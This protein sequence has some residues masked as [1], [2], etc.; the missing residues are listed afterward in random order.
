M[1]GHL[2]RRR[3][4]VIPAFNEDESL[5]ILLTDLVPLLSPSDLV[6]VVDDSPAEIAALTQER[7]ESITKTIGISTIYLSS[8]SKSGRGNAVRRGLKLVLES[9]SNV[10]WFLECD[11]DGSH[12]P[13]DIMTVLNESETSDVVIGSRYL[14]QSRIVGWSYSRRTQSR[15]LNFL[16]P[17][18]LD[19][20]VSDMTNGLRRYSR[21]AVETIVT[22]D[23]VSSSFIH[24]SEQALLLRRAGLSFVEVPIIFEE[25]VAGS[26]SVT[27]S[28]LLTSLRGLWEIMKLKRLP[29]VQRHL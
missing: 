1:D 22:G 24:L 9:F 25:R 19:V 11:A 27:I 16:I 5:P 13:E 2:H 6:V 26:S 15:L 8:Q 17:K 14:R 7:V 10:A 29:E 12:R 4:I 21:R 23:A 18:I 20:P 28:E 3:A